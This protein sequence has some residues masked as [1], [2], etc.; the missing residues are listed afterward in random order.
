MVRGKTVRL[1]E[2]EHKKL[3]EYRGEKFDEGI[4]LGYVIG[5]LLDGE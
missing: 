1:S 4:P 5:E 3:T 2:E